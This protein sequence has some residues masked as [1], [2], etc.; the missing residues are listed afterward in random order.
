M[1]K[2]AVSESEKISED[3]LD[4]LQELVNIGVGRAADSL[5]QLVEARIH[6]NVPEIKVLGSN[7]AHKMFINQ[8]IIEEMMVTQTFAGSID[9]RIGLLFNVQSAILLAS[10]LCDEEDHNGEMS[11]EQEGILLEVGNIILNGVM[12]SIFNAINDQLEHSVP[13]IV[14]SKS[15]NML[16]AENMLNRPTVLLIDVRMQVEE[17]SIEG[18][19]IIVFDAEGVGVNLDWI[20]TMG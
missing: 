15:I 12:G 1:T 18:S 8:A 7:D 2:L 16:L 11:L 6:L 4:L 17:S 14:R 10:M 13:E 9:G 20:I 19:M 3:H 5:S